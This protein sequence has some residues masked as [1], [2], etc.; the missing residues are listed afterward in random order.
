[1]LPAVRVFLAHS[2]RQL[3]A[4][5]GGVPPTGLVVLSIGS[6]QIGAAIAKSLFDELGP[7]G[8]VFLRVFFAA[9]VLLLLWRPRLLGYVRANYF[10][11]I[12]FGLVLA[13]MNL[14]FYSAIERI[15]LGIAVTLE[16]VGPLGVAVA[17]SRRLEDLLWVVLAAVGIVMLAPVGGASLDPLGVG[18]AL[19]A[20]SFWAA[21]IL[22]GAR[23]GRA[24]PGGAGLAIAMFIA[25]VVLLPVGV[26]G[27]GSALLE[28]RLLTTGFGVALLSSALPYS[29]EIEALRHLSARVFGLLLS[30]EPAIAALVGFFILGEELGLRDII[31]VSLI[32]VATVGASQL[33]VNGLGD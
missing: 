31:A 1:M 7:A 16:F 17:G 3:R 6:T 12:L 14:S 33:R 2:A 4:A 23:T 32:T 18:L 10:V 28:P 19:L 27:G 13:G 26:L 8:T 30:L 9:V 20:G 24:F 5:T 22:L 29:L 11:V 15:P 25:A 21:Y